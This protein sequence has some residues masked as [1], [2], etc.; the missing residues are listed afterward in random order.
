MLY[1]DPP[2]LMSKIIIFSCE[3]CVTNNTNREFQKILNTTLERTS[4]PDI[5]NSLFN[6]N[7]E[8]I[9]V[10]N[11][12]CDTCKVMFS[13][14]YSGIIQNKHLHPIFQLTASE[15][16]ARNYLYNYNYFNN[17]GFYT[18]YCQCIVKKTFTETV[19]D[20]EVDLSQMIKDIE[21]GTII[22]FVD[23]TMLHSINNL[24]NKRSLR[25]DS[26][27]LVDLITDDFDSGSSYYIVTDY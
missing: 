24:L 12:N 11:Y 5:L 4:S 17:P 7:F 8:T 3:N 9:V 10:R 13:N 1:I 16:V 23:C 26:L 20:T 15:E 18:C 2:P 14:F 25:L 19:N 27:N 21:E 6:E 22:N